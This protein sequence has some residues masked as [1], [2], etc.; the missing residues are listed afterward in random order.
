M[1]DRLMLLAYL[2]G[3]TAATSVHDLRLLGAALLLVALL[4]GRALPHVFRRA[5]LAILLFNS[6]VT[7]SYVAFA[8]WQGNFSPRYVLLV[9]LRVLL[10]TSMTFLLAER[11]NPF[12]AFA[13]SSSLLYLTTLCYSQVLTLRRLFGEFRHAFRSRSIVR[14]GLRDLYRHGAATVAFF[15]RK[16]VSDAGEIA[17]AMTSRGFFDD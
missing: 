15:M 5:V 13:F 6:V 9:N 7:V 10:L 8:L 4:C 1:K 17:R 16:S 11:F 14:P 2:A 12:R 3:V